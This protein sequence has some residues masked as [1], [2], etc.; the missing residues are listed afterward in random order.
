[1]MT[2]NGAVEIDIVFDEDAVFCP[3]FKV[4]CLKEKCHAFVWAISDQAH[5]QN[6]GHKEEVAICMALHRTRLGWTRNKE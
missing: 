3:Y 6:E 4:P 2:E 1:M 5:I